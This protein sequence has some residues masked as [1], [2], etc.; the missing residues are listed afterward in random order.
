MGS[1]LPSRMLQPSPETSKGS[2]FLPGDCG[3]C[4]LAPTNYQ[5]SQQKQG[6]RDPL[7]FSSLFPDVLII[8]LMTRHS[9]GHMG[10]DSVPSILHNT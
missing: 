3:P 4:S 1:I 2:Q 8:P 9:P 7:S 10:Y 6:P 5:C